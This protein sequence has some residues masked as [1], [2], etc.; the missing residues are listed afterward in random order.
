MSARATPDIV[1]IG[2]H[3]LICGDCKDHLPGLAFDT[4]LGDPPYQFDTSGGGA[5]REARPDGL[6]AIE[7]AGLGEGFDQ[8]WLMGELWRRNA[9]GAMVFC[10]NDQ[11]DRLMAAMRTPFRRVALCCWVKSNPQ[12]VA[13]KHYLPDLE[14]WVHGWNEG[15]HPQRDETGLASVRRAF[16]SPG[17]RNEYGHPTQKPLPLMKKAVT[18]LGGRVVCDPYMGTGSTGVAAVLLGK[19]FVG[20]ERDRRWFEVAVQR[21][22]WAVTAL[23]VAAEAAP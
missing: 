14:F 11:V 22:R 23:G 5:Y 6:D 1:H 16:A 13:N 20:I 17:G 19:T 2:P 18:N 10:H 4:L 3:T 21:V 7:A 15:F 8:D 9:G 12:P